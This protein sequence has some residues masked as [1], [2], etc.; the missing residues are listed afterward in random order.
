MSYLPPWLRTF[1]FPATIKYSTHKTVIS[2]RINKDDD[3]DFGFCRTPE[4][5]TTDGS[6]VYVLRYFGFCRTPE[7]SATDGA[8]VY[9]LRYF[10]FWSSTDASVALNSGV[11]QMHL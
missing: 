2:F 1:F 9:V 7:W 5:N 10:G 6:V 8:V 4:W 11:L 3:D